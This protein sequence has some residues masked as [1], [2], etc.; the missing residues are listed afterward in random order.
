MTDNNENT[1]LALT[2]LD[3]SRRSLLKN[4]AKVAGIA[5][6]APAVSFAGTKLGGDLSP[7]SSQAELR[8]PQEQYIIDVLQKYAA[9]SKRIKTEHIEGFAK[10]FVELNAGTDVSRQF[11]GLTGEY[12]LVKLFIRS[13]NSS[14]LPV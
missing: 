10:G 5:A 1:G 9:K 8:D 6:I 4:S 14:R 7:T 2:S 11:D 13:V 3:T 12:R